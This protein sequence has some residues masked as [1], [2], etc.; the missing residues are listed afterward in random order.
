M[1]RRLVLGGDDLQV[2]TN[3]IRRDIDRLIEGEGRSPTR[4]CWLVTGAAAVVVERCEVYPKADLR[5]H[6]RR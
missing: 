1:R 5:R 4:K 6:S 3:S 2:H